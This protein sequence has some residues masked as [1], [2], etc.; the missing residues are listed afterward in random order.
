MKKSIKGIAVLLAALMCMSMSF[1]ASAASQIK[2]LTGDALK[3]KQIAEYFEIYSG[4]VVANSLNK[5]QSVTYDFS[6]Q[7]ARRNALPFLSYGATKTWPAVVSTQQVMSN[8]LF[9]T[10]TTKLKP[11]SG[12]DW[13]KSY[14][15]LGD[16]KIYRQNSSKYYVDAALY[17]VN[18]TSLS[19]KKV[20]RIR[21]V[22]NKT[23]KAIYGFTVKSLKVVKTGNL[24]A[25]DSKEWDT[26]GLK[27]ANKSPVAGITANTELNAETLVEMNRLRDSVWAVLDG[28]EVIAY[29]CYS[30]T[31]EPKGRRIDAYT[32]KTGTFRYRMDGDTV[33]YVYE[34]SNYA[35][36]GKVVVIND[37]T[38]RNS[39]SKGTTNVLKFVLRGQ[40]RTYTCYGS[41]KIEKLARKYFQKNDYKISS[42]T[43]KNLVNGTIVLTV[44]YY[45]AHG[46]DTLTMT[47]DR[48]TAKGYIGS[49]TGKMIDLTAYAS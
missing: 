45:S 47:V 21:L 19:T 22:L 8:Y 27:K 32:G 11:F 5:G 46:T 24:S 3:A 29:Y 6:K 48:V 20:G 33:Y 17:W 12:M 41:N 31:S 36:T 18:A 13:S 35:G 15:S 44:T 40:G 34:G 2:T 14:P 25:D 7:A 10:K 49:N 43:S 16:Y 42:I 9:M 37:T 26:T 38:M 30:D 39:W 4:I 1:T 23:T 28:D